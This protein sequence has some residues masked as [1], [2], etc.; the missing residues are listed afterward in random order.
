V[1][2]V[3]QVLVKWSSWPEEMATWDDTESLKHRFPFAPAW[4]QAGTQGEG[5]VSTSV[6]GPRRSSRQSRPNT[7]VHGPDRE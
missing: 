2:P 3:S 5:G 1:T 4:G 7:G 6:T